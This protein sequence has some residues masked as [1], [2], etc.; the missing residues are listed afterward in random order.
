[1]IRDDVVFFKLCSAGEKFCFIIIDGGSME[2]FISQEI[3]DRLQLKTDKLAQPYQISWFKDRDEVPITRQSLVKFFIEKTY[4][5]EIWCDIVP[6]GAD[7]HLTSERLKLVASWA[8]RGETCKQSP[9]RRLLRWGQVSWQILDCLD[10]WA[11]TDLSE[12]EN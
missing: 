6:V 10:S 5:D 12:V 7:F 8:A 11:P 2:N 3:I 9:G 4:T 1:M